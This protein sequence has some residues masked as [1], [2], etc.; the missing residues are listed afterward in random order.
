MRVDRG[1]FTVFQQDRR[2]ARMAFQYA[3][4]LG[5]AIAAISDESSDVAHWL[6]IH[7]YV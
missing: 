2:D 6:I 5:S 4:E 3:D 1:V 7:C